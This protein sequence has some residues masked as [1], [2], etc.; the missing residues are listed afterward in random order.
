MH[1][2]SPT[3][4]RSSKEKH[5]FRTILHNPRAPLCCVHPR[6]RNYL[7][8]LNIWTQ[9]NPLLMQSG[10]YIMRGLSLSQRSFTPCCASPPTAAR[11]R[12]RARP[13]AHARGALHLVLTVIYSTPAPSPTSSVRSQT[14]QPDEREGTTERKSRRGGETES[15]SR[16]ARPRVP[17][18]K[19][20]SRFVSA[21]RALAL[22]KF[23]V[24]SPPIQV[25]GHL[26][27]G[28]AAAARL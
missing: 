20:V 17:A 4:P 14:R 6:K 5:I 8:I 16:T 11:T 3:P 9:N 2:S 23:A 15:E 13:H 25:S 7:Y 1:F 21:I 19:S 27:F 18:G 26:R 24:F 10:R 22:S 28:A 12:V